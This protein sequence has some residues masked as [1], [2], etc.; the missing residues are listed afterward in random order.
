[1]AT[2]EPKKL[3]RNNTNGKK[4][5]IPLRTMDRRRLESVLSALAARRC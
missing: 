5:M 3:Q 4:L 2:T 1:M